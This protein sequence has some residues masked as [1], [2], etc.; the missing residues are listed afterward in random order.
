MTVL[1]TT[2][3]EED[4]HFDAAK[5]ADGSR[6]VL[7]VDLDGYE[8]PLHLLL[9][10]SRNQKVDLRNV[11]ILQLADQYLD[12]IKK[13]KNLRIELAADYLVMAAWLT[14]LKSRLILPKPKTSE[15]APDADELAAVLAFRLQ[16][17]D[18]M[19][20]ASK[21]LQSRNRAGINVMLR[22]KPE[23]I[24]RIRSPIYEASIYDLLS[25]YAIKR[26]RI[27]R[28]KVVFK[29]PVLLALEE[30]RHRLERILG[31]M[32]DW[33]PLDQMIVDFALDDPDNKPPRSS[34]LASSLVA[35]LELAKEGQAELRQTHPFAP[36][37]VRARQL[38]DTNPEKQK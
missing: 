4:I 36:L 32:S 30:A 22:G 5:A 7:S 27:A 11:S 35:S 8:G 3:F 19:R 31:K 15:Q 12:F 33:L 9:E 13:I 25:A 28:A 16:R 17:L 29:K 24:R 26:S 18:A 38:A 1:N 2:E 37:F 23:G 6:Q 21:A 10:L 14:Y 34:L 20:A